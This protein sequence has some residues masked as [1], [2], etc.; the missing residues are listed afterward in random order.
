MEVN[1]PRSGLGQHGT[2]SL[3]MPLFV[4]VCHPPKGGARPY[5]QHTY[6]L[7]TSIISLLADAHLSVGISTN[8]TGFKNPHVAGVESLDF[9]RLDKAA[10]DLFPTSINPQHRRNRKRHPVWGVNR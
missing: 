6:L 10:G 7:L 3:S 2:P 5:T 8:L 1:S 9:V 4:S